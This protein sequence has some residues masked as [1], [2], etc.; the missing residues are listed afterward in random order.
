MKYTITGLYRKQYY[1][2]ANDTFDKIAFDLYGDENIASY[3]IAVNPEYSDVIK[4]DAGI[5]LKLPVL[6]LVSDPKLPSWKGGE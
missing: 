5:G 4:F 1:T 2:I 6:E 3:I